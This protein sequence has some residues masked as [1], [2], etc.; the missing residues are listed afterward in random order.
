MY[1]YRIGNKV[2]YWGMCVRKVVG[3]SCKEILW[4][5]NSCLSRDVSVQ[6]MC[7]RR[8]RRPCVIVNEVSYWGMCVRKVVGNPVKKCCGG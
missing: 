8:L 3:E 7:R 2:S 4:R 1:L 6:N 5:V